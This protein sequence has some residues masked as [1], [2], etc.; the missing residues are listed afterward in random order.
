MRSLVIM[1]D[2]ATLATTIMP[3][4][5]EKPPMNTSTASAGLSLASGKASTMVSGSVPAGSTARPAST[6]GT[7]TAAVSAR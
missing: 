6:T 3:V 1:I 4:A 5:A 2:S 7:I